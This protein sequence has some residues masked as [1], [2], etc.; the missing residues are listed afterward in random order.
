MQ[1]KHEEKIYMAVTPSNMLPLGTQ[2]PAFTLLD[3]LSGKPLSLDELKSD[4]ATVV[5]FICNH[6]PY[7]KYIQQQLVSM[8]N[9]YQKKNISFIAISSNDVDK[10]PADN[11]E[12]MHREAETYH[13]SFPYL[14][15]ETQE[16]AKAYRA[17]CTP[18]FYIFDKDLKCVYRGRFDDATP[19]NKNPVTGRD[20]SNALD[21]ILA[22][23]PVDQNQHPSMGCNIKWRV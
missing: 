10:Y 9:H 22:D 23:K 15:D 21:N 12:E 13:Y 4:K 8:T 3:T 11:P 19:G 16:I 7:V 17:A 20:L 5:M 2:A 6:C 14:Y 1:T 18:D